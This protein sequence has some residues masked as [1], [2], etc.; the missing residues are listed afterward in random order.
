MQVVASLPWDIDAPPAPSDIQVVTGFDSAPPLSVSKVSNA[1]FAID[2]KGEFCNWF[3]FRVEGAKGH[4]VRIDLRSVPLNK[5]STLNPVYS[6]VASVDALDAFAITDLEQWP[7]DYE[8][9]ARN[10][11]KLP[12][13]SGQKW[14]FIENVWSE[15][16]SDLC[17]ELK[18]PEDRVWI[19]MRYPYT[20][21]Y[22]EAYMAS[23]G[24]HPNVEVIE[25]GRSES[26]RPLHVV[27]VSGGEEAERRNP[28]IVMYAREHATEQDPSWLVQGV[29][30]AMRSDVPPI[31][32]SQTTLLLIPMLDPDGAAAG[33]FDRITDTFVETRNN[34]TSEAYSRYFMDWFHSGRPIDLVLNLHCVE[35]KE[36]PHLACAQYEPD[37]MRGETCRILNE[38]FVSPIVGSVGYSTTPE[39]GL[40]GTSYFRLGG[41]LHQNY[42]ALHVPYE[43]NVQERKRHLTL[44]ELRALGIQ[45]VVATSEFIDARAGANAIAVIRDRASTRRD[46][47][48]RLGPKIS[49]LNVRDDGIAMEDRISFFLTGE[50]SPLEESPRSTAETQEPLDPQSALF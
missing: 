24:S 12:D 30:E 4:T 34:P 47:W 23:I 10:G 1:H 19:A 17:F 8:S 39:T 15:N 6:T 18:M 38:D 43:A 50:A 11:P 26:G 41:W 36:S 44:D 9:Q 20:P 33:V 13:T 5:W 31:E 25:I 46:A 29:I 45:L 37:T 49:K 7:E 35:S 3:M 14:H 21:G 2:F 28:C 16:K 22:H 32:P 27:K 42:G 48:V 40:R